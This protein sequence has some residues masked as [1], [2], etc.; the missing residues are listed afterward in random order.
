MPQLA[1]F[2]IKNLIFLNNFLDKKIIY[3][4]IP[5]F[6]QVNVAKSLTTSY[7]YLHIFINY[8]RIRE[9]FNNMTQFLSLRISEFF[10]QRVCFTN[11]KK[12]CTI[13]YF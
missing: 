4:F 13:K 5:I 3:F 10:F 7:K 1:F 6:F 11:S 9:K 8:V 12:K 2:L